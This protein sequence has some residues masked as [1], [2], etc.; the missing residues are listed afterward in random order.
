M[1]IP[2]RVGG[3]EPGRSFTGRVRGKTANKVI[4]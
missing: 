4:S 3:G 2:E 1:A